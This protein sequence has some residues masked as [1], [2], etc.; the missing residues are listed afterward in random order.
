MN[1][2]VGR[3]LIPFCGL[4]CAEKRKH[5]VWQVEL[6]D[7]LDRELPVMQQKRALQRIGVFNAMARQVEDVRW[8]SIQEIA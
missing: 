4:A 5:G 8:R 2:L 6:H 7:V 3:I 1:R